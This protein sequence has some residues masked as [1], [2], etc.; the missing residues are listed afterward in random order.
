[1]V[2]RMPSAATC[3]PGPDQKA[4]SG[5]WGSHR[6]PGQEGTYGVQRWLT[7]DKTEMEISFCPFADVPEGT[8]NL[9]WPG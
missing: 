6:K 2:K 8:R 9:E 4:G 3:E 5:G 1:M 7:E